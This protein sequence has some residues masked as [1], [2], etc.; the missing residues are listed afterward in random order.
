MALLKALKISPLRCMAPQV[1]E[2]L[3]RD[4][5]YPS[6]K[7]SSKL[8]DAPTADTLPDFNRDAS[9]ESFESASSTQRQSTESL[10]QSTESQEVEWELW[11]NVAKAS[12][13]EPWHEDQA[14]FELV[15]KLQVAARNQGQVDM[16]KDLASGR[17]AAVKRMP[18]SWTE[19]NHDEFLQRHR[20]ETEMPW[21][22]VG[23][24]K[25]LYAKGFRF[26]CEPLG[27]FRS[28]DE[29]FVV[30]AL[31]SKGD[32]FDWCQSIDSPG[33][34]RDALIA[35][36][37]KQC[38][39][40][41]RHLHSLDI[42]HCDISLENFLLADHHG[43]DHGK[44]QVKLIDFGMA[45]IKKHSVF[46]VRGKPSYQS[47]EMH[48]SG[49]YDPLLADSFSLGVVT[50]C[51]FAQDYPWL[52][53]RPGSCK[54]FDYVHTAGMRA[55]LAKRKERESRKAL[56]DILNEDVVRILEELLAVD[57]SCRARL[58]EM[59]WPRIE[60]GPSESEAN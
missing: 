32:L 60:S 18:L 3:P 55:Y 40:A 14:R 59:A 8:L 17:F 29:T 37:A 9:A 26:I 57:P 2:P 4:R 1:T 30:S 41:V 7:A 38:F 21:V 25:Y 49:G 11:E 24:T 12:E 48:I 34:K 43:C 36:I 46:G 28:K 6:A 50:F 47:P 58:S 19:R 45:S 5:G 54:C 53:T 56:L 22:D 33:P 35:P 31:A 52:S 51:L 20:G 23:L 15:K 42:A 10:T 39:Q 27:V 13:A 44:L 16:M